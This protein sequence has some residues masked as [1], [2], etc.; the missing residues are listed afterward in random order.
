M[1]CRSILHPVPD[2]I[3]GRLH[4]RDGRGP[5]VKAALYS[6]VSKGEDQDPENQLL[7]LREWAART[8]ADV[9]GEYV[10]R[11]SSRDTRPE[12]EEVLRLARLGL[13]ETI[14]VAGLDRWGRTLSELVLEL[15]EFENRG[16]RF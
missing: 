13:I 2:A 8:G 12:K 10:D 1:A 11:A 16:I 15:D 9:V 7:Q 14:V 5:Q 3:E 4:D 6:R